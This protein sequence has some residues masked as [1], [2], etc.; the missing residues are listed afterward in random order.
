MTMSATEKATQ[1][2]AQME[3]AQPYD[4][5]VHRM[6]GDASDR[7]YYRVTYGAFGVQK[8]AVMMELADTGPFIK[9]EEVTL[10]HDESG[11]LPFL[12]IHRFLTGLGTPVPKVLFQ[13]RGLGVLLLEDL[14]DTLLVEIA[15]GND[16]DQIKALYH[17]AIDQLVYLQILGTKRLHEEC[18]A[19]QQIY[20]AELFMWEFHHFVE[21]GIEARFGPLPEK[22]KKDLDRFFK[23]LT[24]HLALLPNVF[25][26][27]DYHSRNLMVAGKRLV[28]ID[29][30]DALLG[31]QTYDLA[32]LLR[33]SYVDLGWKLADDLV[34]YY[35][36]SWRERGGWSLDKRVFLADLWATALQRNLK[37]AGRFVFIERV[38][39]KPG[40]EDLIPLTLSY[41]PGYAERVPALAP[42][43]DRL[44]Q[45]APE[46]K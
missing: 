17:R 18:L 16:R 1:A 37:A 39:Q 28:I 24:E 46:I 21:Y 19:C 31:P 27:R 7:R 43:I 20:T 35:L 45:H 44:R 6:G 41:L 22:E 34:E 33:D 15:K 4:L 13:D 11:E 12:N 2:V 10:Y 38:K 14:G 3:K 9:S 36:H 8:T 29:F 32:S 26:H 23:P 25:V 40:Y 5:L 30:Q 42:L